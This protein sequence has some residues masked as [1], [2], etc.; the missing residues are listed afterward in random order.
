MKNEVVDTVIVICRASDYDENRSDLQ[1][2]SDACVYQLEDRP[3]YCISIDNAV[4]GLGVAAFVRFGRMVT[5]I[6]VGAPM[7][8]YYLVVKGVL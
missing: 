3:V 5:T 2:T 6:Y 7:G 4:R 1:S 8:S